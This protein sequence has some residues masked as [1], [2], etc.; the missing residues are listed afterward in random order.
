MFRIAQIKKGA[1]AP[2]PSLA[3]LLIAPFFPLVLWVFVDVYDFHI[4]RGVQF[5]LGP[6]PQRVDV[7]NAII[8]YENFV[9]LHDMQLQTHYPPHFIGWPRRSILMPDMPSTLTT[10]AEGDSSLSS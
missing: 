4:G 6:R 7:D 8:A 9:A 1:E 3:L 10:R 2:E 5:K